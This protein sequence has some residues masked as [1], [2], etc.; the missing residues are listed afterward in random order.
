MYRAFFP[1]SRKVLLCSSMRVARACLGSRQLQ[2]QP[3]SRGNFPNHC[4]ENLATDG[5]KRSVHTGSH[6]TTVSR[7]CES[8][9]KCSTPPRYILFVAIMVKR[10]EQL[11]LVRWVSCADLFKHRK[12]W[13]AVAISLRK[14]E[15]Q[16]WLS[17]N[18]LTV[19]LCD[20][21]FVSICFFSLSA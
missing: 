1:V 3:I 19:V 21:V 17:H 6:K 18:L 15:P 20:P 4:L 7:L 16:P 2:Y 8:Q 12:C 10:S 9:A 5:K 13:Y 14:K 11:T